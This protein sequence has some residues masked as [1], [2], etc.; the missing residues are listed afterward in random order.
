[1]T[2]SPLSLRVH[3]RQ[4]GRDV[5]REPAD[6]KRH[7]A[8]VMAACELHGAEPLQGAMADLMCGC[9]PQALASTRLLRHPRVVERL[10]PFVARAFRALA[11]QGAR[12]PRVSPLAT[13]YSLLTA[14]S[15]DVP[16][17]ALLC[18]VDDSRALAARA[19]PALLAGDAEAEDAFLDHCEGAGDSLAFMLASR[20]LAQ[21]GVPQSQR[22]LEVFVG[23][24]NGVRM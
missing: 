22:W 2:D 6:R 4:T 7:E 15:L 11:D 23:L 3:F 13:R 10:A 5:L 8:R 12:L 21:A 18:G 9:K 24:Q 20:A 17:R 1:M 19:I 16:R 14:P